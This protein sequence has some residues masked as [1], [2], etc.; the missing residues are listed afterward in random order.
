[1]LKNPPKVALYAHQGCNDFVFN[2]PFALLQSDYQGQKLFELSLCSL[3]GQKVKSHLGMEIPVQYDL[4]LFTQVDVIVIAGWQTDEMPDKALLNALKQ[5]NERGT[6]IIALCYGTYVLAYAGILQGKT[7]TT[8]WLA[9]DDFRQRFPSIH[10]DNNRLYVDDGNILTS[11][12]A[13]GGLDCL[14]HWIRQLYGANVANDLARI[15]VA[16]P[17]GKADKRSLFVNLSQSILKIVKLIPCWI[18]CV[19]ILPKHTAWTI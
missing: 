8:H 4:D 1:M 17:H 12:G 16:P 2:I 6:K 15:L 11:A 18:F 9:E 3:N 19:K 5:A 7:A 14:L 13:S 10:L